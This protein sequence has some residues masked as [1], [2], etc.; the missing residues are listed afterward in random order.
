MFLTTEA[1]FDFH[2]LK[3]EKSNLAHILKLF[4][5]WSADFKVET[6]QKVELEQRWLVSGSQEIDMCKSIEEK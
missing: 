2:R 3:K 1:K 5:P 4:S 6:W